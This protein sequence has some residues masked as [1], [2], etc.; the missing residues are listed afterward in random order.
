MLS[1]S[2]WRYRFVARAT[3]PADDVVG[4]VGHNLGHPMSRGGP[5]RRESAVD[6]ALTYG[7]VR[8]VVDVDINKL[9][10][11]KISGDGCR[12]LGRGAD[13]NVAAF[14]GQWIQWTM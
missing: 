6:V 10:R 13:R 1:L 2:V 4:V 7:L 8:V 14:D 5:L 12:S 9:D 3:V 11:G